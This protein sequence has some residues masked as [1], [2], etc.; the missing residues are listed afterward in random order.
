MQYRFDQPPLIP[1]AL[2]MATLL[3][4]GR[5]MFH[6]ASWIWPTALTVVDDARV[7]F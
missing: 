2:N 7:E 6:A 5:A 3:L 1:F 4:V